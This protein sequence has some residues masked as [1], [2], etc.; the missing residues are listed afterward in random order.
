[1]FEQ[2]AINCAMA[3]L[4]CELFGNLTGFSLRIQ[5]FAQ[6][7]PRSIQPTFS[8]CD[9]LLVVYG[10]SPMDPTEQFLLRVQDSRLPC[11]MKY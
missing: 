11:R 5:H 8:E 10:S 7:Q 2:L 6:P 1:M 9:A 3:A 4:P